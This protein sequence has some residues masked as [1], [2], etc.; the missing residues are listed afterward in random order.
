[1]K[2][3]KRKH[4]KR[5]QHAYDTEMADKEKETNISTEMTDEQFLLEIEQ[6]NK[7]LKEYE[8]HAKDKEVQNSIEDDSKLESYHIHKI[9]D[10]WKEELT[11][12]KTKVLSRNDIFL[13][14]YKKT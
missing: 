2:R 4:N 1:M 8:C 6:Y 12:E 14:L 9:I 11:T 3:K 10:D 13:N 5:G 7:K